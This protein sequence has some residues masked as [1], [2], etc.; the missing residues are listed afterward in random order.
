MSTAL[1]YLPHFRTAC[2][3]GRRPS[4]PRLLRHRKVVCCSTAWPV[5]TAPGSVRCFLL[6][7]AGTVPEAIVDDWPESVRNG[8]ALAAARGRLNSEPGCEELCRKHGTTTE[9][10]FR[11][12]VAGLHLEPV[13]GL[14]SDEDRKAITTWRGS[15]G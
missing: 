12:V 9:G 6:T 1:F 3:T 8:A 4:C 14:M 11:V 2:P 13:I 15:L 5:A 7:V 10:A